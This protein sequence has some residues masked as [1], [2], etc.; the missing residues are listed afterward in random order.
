[1]SYL[2]IWGVLLPPAIVTT[3]RVLQS[4]ALKGSRIGLILS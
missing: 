1:V 4:T 2:A 3:I